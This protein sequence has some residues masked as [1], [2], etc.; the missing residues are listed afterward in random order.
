[1]YVKYIVVES[2][3]VCLKRSSLL[4]VNIAEEFSDDECNIIL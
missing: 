3:H 4:L 2:L 1:M